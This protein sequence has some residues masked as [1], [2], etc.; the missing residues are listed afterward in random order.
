MADFK[1]KPKGPS[2]TFFTV[3]HVRGGCRLVQI[4]LVNGI[5]TRTTYSDTDVKPNIIK[6][7]NYHLLQSLL[8]QQNEE[9]Q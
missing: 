7:L 6:K 3:E 8:I 4:D 5:V 1:Q 9:I 2:G